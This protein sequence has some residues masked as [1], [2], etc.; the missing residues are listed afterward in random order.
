MS[1]F[2]QF[3]IRALLLV[4]AVL[5]AIP[6]HEMGHAAAAYFLGDRS[7]RYFGYFK[8]DPRRFLEPVGVIAVAVALVGWG[9]R[10]PI[11][12]NR[13]NTTRQKVLYELGGPAANLAVAIVLGLILQVLQRAGLPYAFEL[14]PG[15]LLAAVYAIVFL[16]LSLFAFNLLPIPGLDGWN[17]IEAIFKSRNARFFFNVTV[18]RREVWAGCAIALLVFQFL[19]GINLLSIVMT[20]FYEPASKISLGVCDGYRVPGLVGLFPCLL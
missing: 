3:L 17:I 11:Q 19:L 8:P 10:V 16:N 15:L 13:I 6:L 12:S 14:G 20:P 1:N 9:R 2:E 18:R 7:V 4:P 5:I